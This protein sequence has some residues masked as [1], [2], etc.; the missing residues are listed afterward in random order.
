VFFEFS[1]GKDPFRSLAVYME[2]VVDRVAVA[3][4]PLRGLWSSSFICYV[5][6]FPCLFIC[7]SRFDESIL[8]DGEIPCNLA[9][10][11]QYKI[12]KSIRCRNKGDCNMLIRKVVPYFGWTQCT[13]EKG[14]V[15]VFEEKDGKL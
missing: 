7:L 5:I 13:N 15:S 11:Q 14:Y 8:L 2:F 1:P 6:S 3:Q 4:I 9:P 10:S 12:Y